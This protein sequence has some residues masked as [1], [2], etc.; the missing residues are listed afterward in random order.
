VKPDVVANGYGLFSCYWSSQYPTSDRWASMSGTSM[1]SPSVAGALALVLEQWRATRPTLSDPLAATLKALVIHT[2]DECGASPGPDYSFGWGL[3]NVPRAAEVLTLN[4]VE[5]LPIIED[6]LA[7][8]ASFERLIPVGPDAGEL[9]ATLCWT[10]PPMPAR[11]GDPILDDPTPQLVNDLDLVLEAPDGTLHY[12]WMLDPL[13]PSYAATTGVNHVDN[14]EQVVV[15]APLEGLWTL[16]ISHTGTLTDGAQT[17]GLIVTGA[18]A[19]DCDGNGL[20]D[21]DEIAQG[22]PDCNGNGV[23]DTCEQELGPNIAQPPLDTAVCKY[24]TL[25]L[26]VRPYTGTDVTYQWRHNGEPL[27]GA[28]T[29]QLERPNMSAAYEGAYDVIV[30]SGCG[31][32]TSAAATVTMIGCPPTAPTTGTPEHGTFGVAPNTVLHW[33]QPERATGYDVYLGPASPP[34]FIGSTDDREWALT[35][36]H[37]DRTYYWQVVATNEFGETAGPIWRF[38][39]ASEPAVE[40]A[41]PTQPTPADGATN[42]PVTTSLSWA[43]AEHAK[44]YQLVVTDTTATPAQFAGNA[45]TTTWQPPA[46]EPGTMYTWRVQAVN[47]SYRTASPLWSFTTAGTTAQDDT[48]DPNTSSTGDQTADPN[49]TAAQDDSSDDDEQAAADLPGT[50]LCPLTATAMLSLSLLGFWRTRPRRRS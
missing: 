21:I 28:T 19:A 14:V 25:M 4:L 17:F 45:V 7:E 12:P 1:S 26:D 32:V 29:A 3:V 48:E 27:A 18:F 23:L 46:L 44:Y 42:V 31:T 30:T 35:A 8:G 33:D 11:D 6:T 50:G 24:D 22:A 47:G 37:A 13:N 39:V 9:R 5:G 10:D 49:A 43:A 16:H 20:I 41:A 34:T 40:P 38:T 15:T 2:A 36:L